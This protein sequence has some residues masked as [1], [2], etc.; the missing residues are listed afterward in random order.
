M[1]KHSYKYY[2]CKF[3]QSLMLLAF[4]LVLAE[5]LLWFKGYNFQYLPHKRAL[6]QQRP[7]LWRSAINKCGWGLE[8]GERQSSE[9]TGVLETTWPNGQRASR[10]HP[11][12]NAPRRVLVLG[13]SYTFG[14]GLNDK[15]TYCW[16]LNERFPNIC[17]DNYGVGGWGTYQCLLLMEAILAQQSYDAVIYSAIGDHRHRNTDFT[18]FGRLNND[19][20]YGIR[21]RVLLEPTGAWR[22]ITTEQAAWTGEDTW[23]T[24]D[25]AKRVCTGW[26][27]QH[28]QSLQPVVSGQAD[29]TLPYKQQVFFAL[30]QSMAALAAKHNCTFQ[31]FML[32][33]GFDEWKSAPPSAKQRQAFI[34]LSRPEM[35]T[36]AYRIDGKITNHPNA[37]CN[38][39][40]ATGIA[41][42]VTQ[43]FGTN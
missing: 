8:A 12:K 25:F 20:Y 10:P 28:G 23:R 13:C 15:D 17:F 3:A 14:M 39:L 41:H 31:A 30:Q 34:D 21:P 9:G 4:L 1:R 37:H 29:P 6:Q 26:R 16:K 22:G 2:L 24:I 19:N 42:W 40:W 27:L 38:E 18:I 11:E 33:E 36:A 35:R 5:D 43:I 32:E 7:S